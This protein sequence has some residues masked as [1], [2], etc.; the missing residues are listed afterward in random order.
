MIDRK[1]RLSRGVESFFLDSLKGSIKRLKE[2][3]IEK[4]SQ[5]HISCVKILLKINYYS[6]C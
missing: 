6:N 2:V 5:I 3:P 4:K 1:N